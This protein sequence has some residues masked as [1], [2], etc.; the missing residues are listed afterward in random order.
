VI[1]SQAL[2]R[3]AHLC[4]QLAKREVALRY[5]GS[6]FGTL[7]SLINPLVMLMVYGFVFALVLRARWPG[8]TDEQG[9][10]A[11]S[12]LLLSGLMIHGF[13]AEC[14]TRAPGQIV[15]NA[16]FVKKVVFPLPVIAISQ[17]L[18]AV[19]HLGINLIVLLVFQI[20]V[21]GVPPITAILAPLSLLPLLAIGLGLMWGLSALAVYFRDLTHIVGVVAT[22]L[23]FLSPALYPLEQV[24]EGLRSFI[25]LN[26]LTFALEHWR[27]LSLWGRLPAL[28]ELAGFWLAGLFV[29]AAG[30]IGF[31]RLR[32]GF[33][34]VL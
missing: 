24:P 6:L 15:A 5:R 33:A 11:Y 31:G 10:L 12:A 20:A 21:F 1:L 17:W 7:W 14:L 25:Y 18:A 28:G 23:L 3:H 29:L 32:R 19:F 13:L 9:P 27:A 4:L 8:L 30:W 34:D 26:P 16:N 22:L 2:R